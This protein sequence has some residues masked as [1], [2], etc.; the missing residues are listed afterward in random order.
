MLNRITLTDIEQ[1]TAI[2]EKSYK[3]P[4]VLFK[5]GLRCGVSDIA[6]KRMGKA[7]IIPNADFYF[8]DMLRFRKISDKITET[9][10]V[11][12]E[13]PL[14]LLLKNGECIYDENHLG[15]TMQELADQVFSLN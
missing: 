13:S 7:G 5:L 15:I 10:S 12:H 2:K 4:Q 11:Y 3:R 1:I 8:I 14:V 9:F 6:L